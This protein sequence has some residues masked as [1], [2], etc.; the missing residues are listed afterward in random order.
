MLSLIFETIENE[1]GRGFVGRRL[2]P[3]GPGGASIPGAREGAGNRSSVETIDAYLDA[4]ASAAPA[5]GGGSAATLVAA[6]GA[7]L[8]AMVARITGESGKHPERRALAERL[9]RVADERRAELLAARA[10][11]ERAYGAVVAAMSLPRATDEQKAART[12]ALQA[13]LAGAAAAP[14]HAASLALEILRLAES[15]LELRNPNLISDLGCAAEFASAALAS[16]AYNV[17]I[18][19]KFMKDRATIDVQEAKLQAYERSAGEV[20]E[21]VRAE[22]ARSLG[23][24]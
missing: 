4:L 23:A 3:S 2:V 10:E 7:A 11:D 9:I 15:A 6:H 8:V 13:A 17:R 14:L 5:P 16:S 24:A 12:V 1:D 19:H 20:L 18:N 21:R 22:T